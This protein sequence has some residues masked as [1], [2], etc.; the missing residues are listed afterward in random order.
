M[1]NFL[2]HLLVGL[3][4]GLWADVA[5]CGDS[6]VHPPDSISERIEAA[7]KIPVPQPKTTPYDSDPKAKAIYTEEYIKAYRLILAA[8]MV[9]CHMGVKGPYEKAFQDGW[10]DGRKTA[11]KDHPEKVAEMY[12][13]SLEDYQRY[14]KEVDDEQKQ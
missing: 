13:V 1:R 4:F 2:R 10:V 5:P 8:V 3:M 14:L 9:D 7:Q 11:M 6:E 12:G